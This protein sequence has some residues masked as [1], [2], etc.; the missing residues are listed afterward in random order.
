MDAT[1]LWWRFW[2][3]SFI[4]AGLSFAAIAAVVAVRG[5]AD[6]RSLIRTLARRRSEE[7]VQSRKREQ[8]LG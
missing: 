7:K 6:L 4:V 3:V 8:N 5:L 1:Q 2:T